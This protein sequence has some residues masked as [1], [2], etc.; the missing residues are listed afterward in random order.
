MSGSGQSGERRMKRSLIIGAALL[1]TP[2]WE[3][4]G[5]SAAAATAAQQEVRLAPPLGQVIRYRATSAKR[6]GTLDSRE[7]LT[8][9]RGHDGRLRLRWSSEILS[10]SAP[11]PIKPIL[12]QIMR[13]V[14]AVP[15]DYELDGDGMP[16]AVVDLSGH[17]ARLTGAIDRLLAAQAKAVG[18]TPEEQAMFARIGQA[19]SRTYAEQTDE[20]LSNELLEQ[21]RLLLWA[22]AS[23]LHEGESRADIARPPANFGS[24]TVR[25]SGQ[26][27]RLAAPTGQPARFVHLSV[28][29]PE[30]VGRA[31]K[32]F[33]QVAV[34]RESSE[35]QA[36][37]NQVRVEKFEERVEV[38]VDPAT[39]L[40]LRMVRTKA[41]Q[42]NGQ[43]GTETLTFVRE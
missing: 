18:T 34:G 9:T 7:N 30:D 5:Q 27:S 39:G 28:T 10:M 41:M 19:I 22:A 20:Q 3:A 8:F 11:A 13:E 37:L 4:G 16:S 24:G 29:D 26:A 31:A 32:A 21:P 17:R 38:T 35:A 43:A 23:G 42:V 15:I 1:L 36:A 25:V 40:P 6:N 33:G 2:V 14:S 12:E